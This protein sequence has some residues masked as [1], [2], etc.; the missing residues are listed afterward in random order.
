MSVIR[1]KKLAKRKSFARRLLLILSSIFIFTVSVIGGVT[2]GIIVAFGRDMP[3]IDERPIRPIAQTTKVYAADGSRMTDFHAEENRVYIKL[4]KVPDDLRNAVIAIED[5][6][7]YEH[8]GID[9]QGIARAVVSNFKSGG[10]VEGGSTLTQQLVKN[11]YLSSEKTFSRKIKEAILAWQLERR[12]TK[13]QILEAYLNTVYFGNGVYGVNTAAYKYFKKSPKDLTLGESALLAGLIRAPVKYSPYDN[14]ETAIKRRDQ[15]IRKMY[16]LKIAKKD[17]AE[18]ALAESL[19]LVPREKEEITIAPFF[20]EYIKQELIKKYGP[21]AVFKGGLRIY[22]T[23]DPSHQKAAEDAVYSTLNRKDDPSASLVSI[24]PKTGHIKAMVGGRD[25]NTEKFNL[26]VQGHRQAGSAFKVFVLVT[27]IAKGFSLN[28]TFVSAPQAIK[29]AKDAPTWRVRNYGNKYR[30]RTTLRDATVWSDNSVYAQLIVKVGASNV[31]K[32]AHSIGIVSDIP[33]VPAIALGGLTTGVSALE[34]ATAGATLANDGAKPDVISITKITDYKG[35]VIEENKPSNKRAIKSKVA[36]AVNSALKDA[37]L[38]GTGRRALIGRPAAGKTG[39]AQDYRDAWF[40]GYTPNL[41]AAVWMGYTY[42]QIP[43]R[44]VHGVRVAGGTF[45]AEIWRKYMLI[46]TKD[47]PA[48]DFK[49]PSGENKSKSYSPSKDSGNN[50]KKKKGDKPKTPVNKEPELAPPKEGQEPKPVP[51]TDDKPDKEPK[52]KPEPSLLKPDKPKPKPPEPKP[53]EP[54]P[55]P[56][57]PEP[58]PES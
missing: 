36:R 24:D 51:D 4:E 46:A 32:M 13:K 6:R 25:F 2:F 50:K 55:E 58:E 15:V 21:N 19:D 31:V 9:Y 56:P 7:F 30:G 42:A 35:T 52:K 44:N 23:L 29:F 17:K 3:N 14:P 1:K 20:V 43:M 38:K 12:S 49:S 37:M 27:A 40:I 47:L 10:I 33:S 53:S 48:E 26:A 54:T 11:R 22:T 18:Q 16:D 8:N 45:P 57:P 28:D 5:E 41:A 34:M 39:T